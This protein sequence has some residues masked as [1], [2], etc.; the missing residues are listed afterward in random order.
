MIDYVQG[1]RFTQALL[2][3]FLV[4]A[5]IVA[6]T[7]AVVMVVLLTPIALLEYALSTFGLLFVLALGCVLLLI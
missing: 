6:T 3:V 4:F 2:T 1:L 7:M 5:K